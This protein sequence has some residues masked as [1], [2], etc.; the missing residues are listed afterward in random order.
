MVNLD[1]FFDEGTHKPTPTGET[2]QIAFVSG[3]SYILHTFYHTLKSNS[4]HKHLL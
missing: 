2:F 1:G 3:K 4:I